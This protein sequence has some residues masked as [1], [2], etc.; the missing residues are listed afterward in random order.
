MKKFFL[1]FSAILM[2]IICGCSKQEPAVHSEGKSMI[3]DVRTPE[4]YAK[5]HLENA[6]NIPHTEMESKIGEMVP[7][8]DT[9]IILYCRTGNRTAKSAKVLNKLGYLNIRDMGSMQ[10]ASRMTG[11]KIIRP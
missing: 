8:K 6:V 5:G 7:A 9:V 2:I 3:L 11:A 10:N 1:T 4:E